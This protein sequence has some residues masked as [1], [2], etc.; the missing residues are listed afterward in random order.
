MNETKNQIDSYLGV[1]A[2]AEA[3]SGAAQWAGAVVSWA[4]VVE[5]TAND[6]D[7]CEFSVLPDHHQASPG[8]NRASRR[9]VAPF[10]CGQFAKGKR[11]IPPLRPGRACRGL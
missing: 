1:L 9:A 3:Q 11:V 5:R 10:G 8:W 2:R 7:R 4:K 6:C